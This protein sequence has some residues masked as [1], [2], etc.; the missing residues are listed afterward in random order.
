MTWFPLFLDLYAMGTIAALL[1]VPFRRIGAYYYRF[2]ATLA[3]VMACAGTVI[4]AP[5]SAFGAGNPMQKAV[6]ALA[7]LFAVLVFVFNVAARMAGKDLRVDAVLMP[8]TM[9]MIFVST[10]AFERI[11]YGTG[12]A[13]LLALHLLTSA[14][15]LGTSLVAMSTG[16]WYLADAALSFDI[17]IRLCRLFAASL[18]LK[19]A[20]SAVYAVRGWSGI[21][22]LEAFDQLVVAVR[23][24]AGLV[25]AMT[26][27]WMS[28]SCAKRKANQSATGILYV[29]VVFV[30]MGECISLY[31]TLKPARGVWIPI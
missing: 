9:G 29:A 11:E 1:A 10:W 13:L 5:W 18:L 2:H 8:V 12:P 21:A 25:L 15:V 19:A 30:L 27:A 7:L 3:L 14:A 22:R 24:I 16:H 28:L 4:G 31:L 20:V 23:V 6:A 26:L 17:L